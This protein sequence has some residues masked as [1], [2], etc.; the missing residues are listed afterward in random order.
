MNNPL[1]Y[2][3]NPFRSSPTTSQSVAGGN[4]AF[5]F[6]NQG[7]SISTSQDHTFQAPVRP[8]IPFLANLNFPYLSKLMNDPVRH[9]SSWPPLP[10]KLPSDIP[11]F[12]GKVGE[13]PGDHITTFHLCC[14]SN[15]LNDDTVWLI[16]FQ[17][18]LTSA[19]EMW[20]IELPSATF[21]SF[22]DLSNVFLNHFQLHVHYNV[23]I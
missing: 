15:S 17:I 5:T 22:W 9:D 1:A 6:G 16:L 3:W 4:L 21:G 10:T 18:T 11:K 7:E 12:E 23:R 19:I 14:S 20:Y 8:K 13:D 2:G